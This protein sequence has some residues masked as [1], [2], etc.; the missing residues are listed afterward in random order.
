MM[1]TVSSC[2]TPVNIY[3]T[4][5]RNNPEDSHL[6]SRRRDNLKSHL[7]YRMLLLLL[8]PIIKIVNTIIIIIIVYFIEMAVF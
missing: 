4:T 1:E 2:E 3:Q 6:H 8:G 7:R 5:R